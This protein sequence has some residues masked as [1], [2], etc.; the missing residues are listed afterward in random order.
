MKRYITRHGAVVD[1]RAERDDH[2]Y[3][4]G[5]IPLSPLGLEQAQLLGKRMKRLGFRGLI[6]ASP[7]IRTMQTA[8]AIAVSPSQRVAFTL[9]FSASKSEFS[10]VTSSST[11]QRSLAL[12]QSTGFAQRPLWAMCKGSLIYKCAWR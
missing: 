10:R 5:D 4:P 1:Y 3:P 6:V 7:Y 2:L 12:S 9:P 8:E 11:H